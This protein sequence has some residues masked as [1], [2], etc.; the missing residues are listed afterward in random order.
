MEVKGISGP[1]RMRRALREDARKEDRGPLT[2]AEL[3]CVEEDRRGAEREMREASRVIKML[4]TRLCGLY[5]PPSTEERRLARARIRERLVVERGRFRRRKSRLGALV[6]QKMRLESKLGRSRR[7][8]ARGNPGLYGLHADNCCLDTDSIPT[9]S[10][11]T[12]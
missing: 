5:D 9:D 6:R 8:A 2:E 4:E 3:R 11:T 10:V 7:S 12:G 1:E